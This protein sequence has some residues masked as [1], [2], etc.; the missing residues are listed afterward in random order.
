[1]D[2][3]STGWELWIWLKMGSKPM[4]KGFTWP[5]GHLPVMSGKA[6][7]TSGTWGCLFRTSES[8]R[9]SDLETSEPFCKNQSLQTLKM[10]TTHRFNYPWV[11][12][13]AGML[14]ISSIWRP[15][16]VLKPSQVMKMVQTRSSPAT[17][18]SHTR[19]FRFI[20]GV[21][22]LTTESQKKTIIFFGTSEVHLQFTRK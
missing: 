8:L 7:D 2:P 10:D 4:L 16:I 9:A 20:P 6:F 12:V 21:G 5:L 22:E 17:P 3:L 18:M 15:I 11:L 1:M 14:W 13:S 19:S